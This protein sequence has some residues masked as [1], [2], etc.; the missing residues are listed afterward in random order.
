MENAILFAPEIVCL[1]MGLILFFS[2]VFNASHPTVYALSIFTGV[3][4]LA[5]SIYTL[6]L[7]GEPFF[8]GIYKVDF[9]SQL[10]KTALALGFLCVT[11]T[12]R[13]PLTF[14]KS[15]WAELPFFLLFSTLGM[16]LMVSA[17]ELLTLYV[18]MELAAYPIY[19]VVALHRN[20]ATNG[21]SATKYMVQGMAAS[22][23]SL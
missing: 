12:C 11:I 13:N 10:I 7:S 16:M 22:A 3:L 17:T 18:A 2:T 15:A 19:I 9:F 6:P 14:H 5:A 23:I 4:A 20:V 1:I 21:E 8:P